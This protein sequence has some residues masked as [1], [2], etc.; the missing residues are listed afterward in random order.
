MTKEK[1]K[2]AFYWAASC[3]GCD[4]AVLDINEKILD[5]AAIADIVFWPF[6]MDFKDSDVEAMDDAEID[7]CL[8]NGAIRNSEQEEMAHLLRRKS[9]TM[10]AFGAC[11]AFGGIPALANMANRDQIM[12]GSYIEAFSV[13]NEEGIIPSVVTQTVD[14]PLHLPEIYNTV[15]TL[16]DTVEVEYTVPGCP[17][18]TDQIL[19][20]V[21]AMATGELPPPG[22]VIASDTALCEECPREK[23]GAMVAKFHRPHEIDPDPTRCLLE[24]GL[25]CMGSVTRGGCGY[26]CPGVSIGCRGCFGPAPGVHDMGAKMTS[27]AASI[28]AA[29]D[30]EAIQKM[31]DEV[32]DPAGTFYRFTLA[33][34]FIPTRQ[35][36]NGK[37]SEK[38]GQLA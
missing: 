26:L 5:V 24:Q 34:P 2:L 12:R 1:L 31:L 33:V 32:V 38:E 17:P 30:D 22:S 25:L 27:V 3:G 14:G 36:P 21:E 35:P 19:A 28:H 7:V 4:V 20:L 6:A 9:K 11:S 13:V 37:T 15:K 10:V 8:F 16:A 18:V 29:N 23:H